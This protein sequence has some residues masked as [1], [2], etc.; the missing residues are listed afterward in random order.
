MTT[1]PPAPPHR[2]APPPAQEKPPAA[3]VDTFASRSI[4][5]SNKGFAEILGF[6]L[7]PSHRGGLIRV[8]GQVVDTTGSTGKGQAYD[9]ALIDVRIIGLIGSTPFALHRGTLGGEAGPLDLVLEHPSPYQRIQVL[10]R[11]QFNGDDDFALAFN[12]VGPAAS[13]AAQA[14][15]AR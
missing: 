8:T 9:F 12:V 5:L 2:G 15:L 4:A 11:L 6:D 3:D 7:K 1:R 10:A 14:R 13:A